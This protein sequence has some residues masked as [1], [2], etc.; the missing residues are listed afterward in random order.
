MKK[1]FIDGCTD[2]RYANFLNIRE[3]DWYDVQ[4]WFP[5]QK[6][7]ELSPVGIYAPEIFNTFQEAKA[8]LIKV[9]ED[10]VNELSKCVDTS[11]TRVGSQAYDLSNG[12]LHLVQIQEVMPRNLVMAQRYLVKKRDF[13]RAYPTGSR[14]FRSTVSQVREILLNDLAEQEPNYLEL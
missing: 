5:E 1:F 8:Y 9:F 3:D 14:Y 13:G 10:S 7:F 4:L 11:V 2:V 6:A 12:Q